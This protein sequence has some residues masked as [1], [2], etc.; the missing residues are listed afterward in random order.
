[1]TKENDWH[2]LGGRY[3][4]Q[5]EKVLPISESI[6]RNSSLTRHFY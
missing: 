3:E 2:E 5:K 6:S 4:G 1:M